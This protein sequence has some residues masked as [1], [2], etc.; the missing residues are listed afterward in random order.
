MTEKE[1][2]DMLNT[3]MPYIKREIKKDNDFIIGVK[4]KNATVVSV[5]KNANGSTINQSIDVKLPFDSVS[6]SVP[7]KT[8]EEIAVG[9]LVCIEYCIDLKNAIA[10]YKV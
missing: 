2:K 4:R 5:Q 1:I 3:L 8:G 10:A 7:N 6:F 9:D